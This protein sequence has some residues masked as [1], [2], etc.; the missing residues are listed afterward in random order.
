MD[1]REGAVAVPAARGNKL[2][3]ATGQPT[4]GVVTV[5]LLMTANEFTFLEKLYFLIFNT[6]HALLRWIHL[7]L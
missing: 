1:R 4:T 6:G 5:T 7:L 2:E 3:K